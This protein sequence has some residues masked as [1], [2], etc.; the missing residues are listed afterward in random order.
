MPNIV[1]I[2]DSL[3]GSTG[4]N[5]IYFQ[6]LCLTCFVTFVEA[7]AFEIKFIIL[8]NKTDGRHAA[9]NLFYFKNNDYIDYLKLIKKLIEVNQSL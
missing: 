4:K 7:T 6:V 2:I 1:E 5:S 8:K 9:Q 3:S